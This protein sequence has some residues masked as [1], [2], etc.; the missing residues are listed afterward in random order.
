MNRIL[1]FLCWLRD[2]LPLYSWRR[3]CA[4]WETGRTFGQRQIGITRDDHG[5]FKRITP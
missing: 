5:K 4:E 3:C 1:R 2:S